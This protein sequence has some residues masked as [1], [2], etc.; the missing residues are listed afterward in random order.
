MTK[1]NSMQENSALEISSYGREAV[2]TSVD[3]E[4]EHGYSG[5]KPQLDA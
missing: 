2:G 1:A 4:K 5:Q 3:R